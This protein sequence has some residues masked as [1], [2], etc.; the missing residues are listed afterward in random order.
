M[1]FKDGAVALGT[2]PVDAAGHASL[3]V[4][5]LSLGGHSIV[6]YFL[7]STTY[8][9]SA[10]PVGPLTI[11]AN[12]PDLSLSTS[13]SSLQVTYGTTSPT[14]NLQIT[15][16]SG[17]AGA[18]SLACSGMPIG[19]TC[20]FNPATVT[21]TSGGTTTSTLV[22]SS[23]TAQSAAVIPL[24]GFLGLL[25]L[26]LSLL[27]LWR[28]RKGAKGVQ[29]LMSLVILFATSFGILLGCSGGTTKAFQETGSKTVLVTA[30][31]GSVTRSV[32]LNV[33]IQ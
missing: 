26:P 10:S 33:T 2:V 20:S 16:M 11:Y 18:V 25:S 3:T 27:A 6:A 32:P 24:K 15:S 12:A 17:L 14:V 28:I 9:A 22:M 1:L 7:A 30:T 13:A 8:S 21:L 31:M 4:N 19:M 23:T 29:A 5:G